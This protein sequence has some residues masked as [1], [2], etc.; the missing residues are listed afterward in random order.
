MDH[1]RLA[2]NGN[3]VLGNPRFAAQIAQ[4]LQRR[5]TR[6]KAGRPVK[7]REGAES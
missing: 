6:G 4:M 7:D 3:T 5:V 1:I 2:T